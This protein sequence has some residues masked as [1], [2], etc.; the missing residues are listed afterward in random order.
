MQVAKTL[1]EKV[2]QEQKLKHCPRCD[3]SKPFAEFRENASRKGGLQTYCS[4]CE[5]DYQRKWRDTPEYRAYAKTKRRRGFTQEQA[6][7]LLASQGGVCGICGSHSSGSGKDWYM[8]HNHV[9]GE[10]RGMLCVTCNSGLGFFKDSLE[11][12]SKAIKYLEGAK[13]HG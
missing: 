3:T 9:T 10:V 11:V 8:D 4:P 12:L 5:T 2:L 1:R 13:N 7:T 6:D